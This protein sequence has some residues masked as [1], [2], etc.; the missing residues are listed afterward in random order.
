MAAMKEALKEKKEV[1]VK[2]RGL[3]LHPPRRGRGRVK[4]L[5]FACLFRS[6]KALVAK[7]LACLL[8]RNA[9]QRKLPRHKPPLPSSP[10]P[11]DS[12]DGELRFGS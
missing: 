11:F 7:I 2:S 10:R 4:R 12:A 9:T 5:I 8:S 6:L 1:A 3:L